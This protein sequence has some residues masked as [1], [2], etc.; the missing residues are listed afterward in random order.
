MSK[1][2]QR[3]T[4]GKMGLSQ[5]K[6][7]ESEMRRIDAYLRKLGAHESVSFYGSKEEYRRYI[8]Q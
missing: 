8:E 6:R 1:D 7:G 3:G 2:S 4:F 5:I